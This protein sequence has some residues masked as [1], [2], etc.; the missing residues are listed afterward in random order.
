MTQKSFKLSIGKKILLGFSILIFIYLG[1]ALRSY[2][3]MNEINSLAEQA[4]PLSY[5]I[6]SL[7]EFAVSLESLDS[8]IDKF[9]TVNYKENQEEVNK[10]FD[11]MHSIIRSIENNADSNSIARLQEIE[12]ILSEIQINFNYLADLE[13]NNSNSRE[14]NEKRILLYELINSQRQKHRE[15]LLET[16]N[17][18]QVNVLDQKKMISGIMKEFLMLGISILVFGVLLSFITSRSIS[19][20]I[21][22]LRAATTEIGH[23]RF[24]V[25]IPIQSNDEIGQLAFAFNKMTQELQKT[26]V[27]KD[28]VENIIKSMFDMLVVAA[29]DGTIKIVNKAICDLLGY[30]SEE[31]AGRSIDMLFYDDVPNS[32]RSFLN[33]LIKKGSIINTEK[34]YLAKDGRKIPVLLS[35]SKMCDDEGNILGVVCVAKDITE[36]RRA[37]DLINKS[38]E[39]AKTVLSSMK[40]AISIIDVN[41]FRIIEVNSVFLKIYGMKKEEVIGKSCYEITHKRAQPCIPPYDICPL[42]DTLNSGEHSTA[43]HVH[44]MKD[45]EKRYVEV[46]TSPIMDDNGK[47]IHV[48]HVARDITDRKQAEEARQISEKKYSTLVEKGNDGIIIIQDGLLKFINSKM[49]DISGYT[50]KEAIG[51]PFFDFV[52]FEFKELV[53]DNYKKRLSGYEVPNNY[54]IEIISK[55]GKNIPVEINAS[56]IDYEGKRAEMAIIRDITDRKRAEDQIK[57]SLKEKE[58]LLKEIHH[59]VKNNMQIVSSLLDHQAQ[60]IKDKNVIEIFTESQNRILSMSLVHEKLYQSKDLAK[61]DFYNYIN[62]LAANLFQIYVVNPGKITLTM[63]IE[64][65]QLDIDLAIPCGLIA[66]ELVTNSLKYAFPAGTKGEITIAFSKKE[67]NMLEF[68]ISDDGIGFP[69]DLDFRKTDSL[70]LHLVTILAENQLHGEINLIRGKGTEF[71]IKFRGIK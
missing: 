45:G 48:I 32:E 46:S 2:S 52:F 22:K 59:R 66:N 70:G 4:V 71:Q 8:D 25:N 51:K 14:I 54:E 42:M 40:D 55:D 50:I 23:G 68:V 5:Q 58:T 53:I 67:E 37:E 12:R 35:M 33:E 69:K 21:G 27:S 47:I 64:N 16:T 61:I 11:N 63:N 65:I 43:E 39:F 62:D 31:L 56:V 57:L 15:L 41:N 17:K 20:P 9:F 60:Y 36:R 24:N 34:N 38:N 1:M 10:D 18:I 6:T 7:Q 3:D 13:Q 19:R 30:R 28:Y 44:F 26:T 49:A 29:P